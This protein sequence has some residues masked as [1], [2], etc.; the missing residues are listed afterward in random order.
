M[1]THCT[2]LGSGLLCGAGT[3]VY[4][5]Q[6]LLGATSSLG[7]TT[8]FQKLIL[9]G[10]STM[11]E[12]TLQLTTALTGCPFQMILLAQATALQAVLSAMDHH[13]CSFD[14]TLIGTFD[15]SPQVYEAIASNTLK[16]A[17]SQQAYVE[18]ASA[19]VMASLFVTTGETLARSVESSEGYYLSGPVLV[20]KGN[21][22]SLAEETCELDAFPV[23]PNTTAAN[24]SEATCPCVNRSQILLAG[25]THGLV[26]DI[27]WNQVYAAAR[28]AG[29]DFNV[30]LRLVRLEPQ[31]TSDEFFATY[32]NQ[33]LAFCNQT[34][35]PI[36]GLFVS[37]TNNLVVNAV[38]FCVS[39]HIPVISINT[40]SELA[41]GAGVLAHVGQAE[42]IA[43]QGAGQLLIKAGV[44]Q[45][46]CLIQEMNNSALIQ[47]C[48]G[49]EDAFNSSSSASFLGSFN[50]PQANGTEF[51]SIVENAVG[52]N[53]TWAGVGALAVTLGQLP[54]ILAVQ[55]RHPSLKIGIFDTSIDLYNAITSK[56][57]LFAVDQNAYL[58]GYLPIP[59]LTWYI[60]TG[61]AL[62]NKFID[63]GPQFVTQVPTLAEQSCQNIF[64]KS[65]PVNT[66]IES[67]DLTSGGSLV[68]PCATLAILTAVW[69]LTFGFLS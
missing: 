48:A 18:G 15:V 17:I 47:R 31:P 26:G 7:N 42:F 11:N 30:Q 67:V 54:Y 3:N 39:K 20:D 60:S 43:G 37:L 55:Q 8:T 28:Q 51:T 34:N 36:S 50:V 61:E 58:Q 65:C 25:V 1:L 9:S 2:F 5:N 52:E 49:M 12:M 6:R 16:F 59:F 66:S 69:S 44:K 14:Q 23:C 33:I 41:I 56:Q 57:V 64:F 45:G 27:F 19:V 40:G 62:V 29:E 63:S 38:K 32:V 21:I 24:G 13:G 68:F 53:G 46:V 10:T 22:P 4:L 35:P